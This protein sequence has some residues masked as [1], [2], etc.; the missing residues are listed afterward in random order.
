MEEASLGVTA[1]RQ[2]EKGDDKAA[3]DV[4]V[5]REHPAAGGEQRLDVDEVGCPGGEEMGA[6]AKHVHAVEHRVGDVE[7]GD[8]PECCDGVEEGRTDAVEELVTL[9]KEF[10]EIIRVYN[11]T[12]LSA[13]AETVPVLR[14]QRRCVPEGEAV[15]VQ[16]RHH[17]PALDDG[18]ASAAV[19]RRL[20]TG[21]A[22]AARVTRVLV[23]AITAAPVAARDLLERGE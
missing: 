4:L 8:R 2:R 23:K 22:V 15:T 12:Q 7:R 20:G 21:D 17:A 10:S 1:R 9:V 13:E 16:G 11:I 6:D 19:P 3:I 18:A 5:E 14:Y